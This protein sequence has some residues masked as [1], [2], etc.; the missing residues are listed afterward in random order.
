MG[1]SIFQLLVADNLQESI[2]YYEEERIYYTELK[3]EL[4]R[5]YERVLDDAINIYFLDYEIAMKLNNSLIS[6]LE[7]DLIMYNALWGHMNIIWYAITDLVDYRYRYGDEYLVPEP[8]KKWL[9]SE[10]IVQLIWLGYDNYTDWF[11]NFYANCSLNH[12]ML[13][14]PVYNWT[15]SYNNTYNIAMPIFLYTPSTPFDIIVNFTGFENYMY[16]NIIY[17][18]L[19][20]EHTYEQI[21]IGMNLNTIAILALGF[22]VDFSLIKKKWKRFYILIILIVTAISSLFSF[23]PWF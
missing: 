8:K 10:E 3:A 11:D 5:H 2:K 14:N 17:P 7:A 4:W 19:N 9:F 15:F 23:I 20:D 1:I 22:L 18:K 13:D 6:K 16:K 21:R 12:D